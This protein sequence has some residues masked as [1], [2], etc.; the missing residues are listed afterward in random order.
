MPGDR[1]FPPSHPLLPT[2]R[3]V[4]VLDQEARKNKACMKKQAE[5]YLKFQD[6][7]FLSNHIETPTRGK[8]IL[9]LISSNN[10]MIIQFYKITINKKLS[11]HNTIEVS[12]NFS[13]NQETKIEKIKKSL[14]HKSL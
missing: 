3:R 4:Y 12:F 1:C 13:Y 6:E 8:A 2:L 5:L 7:N 11:D 9:D 10:H 14:F